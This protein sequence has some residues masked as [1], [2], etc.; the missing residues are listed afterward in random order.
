[1][2]YHRITDVFTMYIAS[3]EESS[4]DFVVFFGYFLNL[5]RPTGQRHGYDCVFLFHISSVNKTISK[6]K[7]EK[8]DYA[9]KENKNHRK[10]SSVL[11]FLYK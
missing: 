5:L 6:A 10:T 11:K 1:M 9:K 7:G 8:G 3:S 4:K 2:L